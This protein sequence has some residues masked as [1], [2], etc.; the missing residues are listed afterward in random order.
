MLRHIWKYASVPALLSVALMAGCQAEIPPTS[1]DRARETLREALDAWKGGETNEAYRA[2]TSVQ[3]FDSRWEEGS[4]LVAYEVQGDGH[5]DGFDW[6]C[7]VKLSLKDT[8]GKTFDEKA[9]YN[10][11]TSP[12]LVVVRNEN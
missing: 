11:S 10:I 6:Q 8:K 12:A 1:P 4:K 5:S 7:K 3:A 2:R 9:V